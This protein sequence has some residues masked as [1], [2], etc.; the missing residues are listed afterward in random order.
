MSTV[1][2]VMARELERFYD[3]KCDYKESVSQIV[4]HLRMRAEIV[5]ERVGFTQPGRKAEGDMQGRQAGRGSISNTEG[6]R[7]L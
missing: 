5:K 7:C 6:S 2:T 1:L 4:A 3:K